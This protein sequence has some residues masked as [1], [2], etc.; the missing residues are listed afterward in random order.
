MKQNQPLHWTTEG[1]YK[2]PFM[3]NRDPSKLE[4]VVTD[5]TIPAFVLRSGREVWHRSER[6]TVICWRFKEGDYG[7]GSGTFIY[8]SPTVI[9]Q[10]GS[11]L[12]FVDYSALAAV[13]RTAEDEV[14]LRPVIRLP[15]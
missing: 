13:Q 6:A 9:I 3:V 1:S 4:D 15:D 12:M 2:G 10:K 11:H 7:D 5:D 14:D 8:A